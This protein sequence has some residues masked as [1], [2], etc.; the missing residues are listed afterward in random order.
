MLVKR[1][2]NENIVPLRLEPLGNGGRCAPRDPS[3]FSAGDIDI[4]VFKEMVDNALHGIMVHDQHKPL[5]INGAWAA[6]HGLTVNE[7][8]AKPTIVDLIHESD[9]ERLLKYRDDRLQGIP[10]PKRYRY[11]GLHADGR[12]IWLEHFVRVIDW[13]GQNVIMSTIVDV[14][15]QER[16]VV[17]LREQR[18]SMKQEVQERSRELIQ[19]NRDLYLHQ[20][21]VDQ[22]GER[23]SVVDTD[24]RFRMSNRA[25]LDFRGMTRSQIVGLHLRETLDADYFEKEAKWRLDQAFNGVTHRSES[26]EF[27]AGRHARACPGYDRAVS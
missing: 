10:V 26:L 14:D 23:I 19:S 27:E 7:V 20:S 16:Q 4:D 25:N 2:L 17:A 24:Y 13:Q 15:D 1:K 3:P 11:R 12:V 6:L 18:Q 5:Y 22:M 8:M 21:I 9:R